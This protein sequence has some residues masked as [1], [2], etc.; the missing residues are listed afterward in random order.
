[1]EK[2]PT[3]DVFGEGKGLC[4]ASVAL[5]AWSPVGA[6]EHKDG[7]RG[8]CRIVFRIPTSV[9]P[10]PTDKPHTGPHALVLRGL[11]ARSPQHLLPVFP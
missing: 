9:Q 5:A 3:W 11:M 4:L 8:T 7:V 10:G 6:R 1:M 2:A